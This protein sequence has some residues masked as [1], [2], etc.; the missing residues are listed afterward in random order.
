MSVQRKLGSKWSSVFLVL[1]FGWLLIQ[2][3]TLWFRVGGVDTERARL[4]DRAFQ[5]ERDIERQKDLVAQ[6]EDPR[7]LEHQA[8]LRLN[9]KLPDEGIAVVYKD[10]NPDSISPAASSSDTASTVSWW[11][12]IVPWFRG[13]L[14]GIVQW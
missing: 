11:K 2:A 4:E 5:I 10:E 3:G 6:A 9:Y 12:R 7:W 8:R 13:E 1:V 14:A